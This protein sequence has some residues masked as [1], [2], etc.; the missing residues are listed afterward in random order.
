MQIHQHLAAI[1]RAEDELGEQALVVG[2]RS[3]GVAGATSDIDVLFPGLQTYNRF[4]ERKHVVLERAGLRFRTASELAAV[5]ER[6]ER[7]YRIP[8]WVADAAWKERFTKVRSDSLRVSF[9]FTYEY[10]RDIWPEFEKVGAATTETWEGIVLDATY[11]AFMPR[12]YHLE[13]DNSSVTVITKMFLYAG[14][15]DVGD[16]VLVR[17]RRAD[18]NSIVV[19]DYGDFIIRIDAKCAVIRGQNLDYRGQPAD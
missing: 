6:Y 5:A 11:S 7:Y 14:V 19:A 15:A 1:E 9:H 2:S 4:C 18:E 3:F 8:R 16:R 17:G 12:Q 13:V 10:Q